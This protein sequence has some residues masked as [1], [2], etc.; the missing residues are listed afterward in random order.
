MSTP[1]PVVYPI[2]VTRCA[3][4]G[5][6][7]WGTAIAVLLARNGNAV[8]L[9]G[10]DLQEL[11]D[12]REN[13]ENERYLPGIEFPDNLDIGEVDDAELWVIAVPSDAVRDVAARLPDRARVVIAAKGLEAG[14]K[15]MS[16]VVAE[17][18]PDSAISSLSGPNLAV[19]IARGVPTATVVA[20]SDEALA[21]YVRDRFMCR[22]FRV[23]TSS[24]VIGVELGGALKNVLAIGAGVS[25]GLGFGDNTKGA[26]IARGLHE[27]CTLGA[28]LGARRET[29]M[30]LSGVGDLFATA[31][32]RLSRNYR[33]GFS[34]GQ[35]ASLASALAELG[36]VAEGVPTASAAVGLAAR[37][38]VDVPVMDS[39][40][41][42][43][44]GEITPLQ[45]VSMLMERT[46]KTEN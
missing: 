8:A 9:W 6:G 29:F 4:L 10:R 15:R 13:R 3:V 46:A 27:M 33:V 24:D 17:A 30:G 21:E 37:C 38:D 40:N 14:G 18:R 42:V 2:G 20:S 7:S 35:G 1:P 16:E 36:Q 5:A 34:L 22:T 19:E 44:L 26:F 32:S 41:R 31:V 23:Y 28:A 25:D 43:L 11:E 12:I 39:V 45:G